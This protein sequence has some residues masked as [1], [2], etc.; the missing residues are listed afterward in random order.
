MFCT[1]TE[2][3]KN[4]FFTLT[5]TLLD[6]RHVMLHKTKSHF[7][8]LV[9]ERDWLTSFLGGSTCKSYKSKSHVQFTSWCLWCS[10]DVHGVCKRNSAPYS[11]P[12]AQQ[13]HYF[14][15]LAM[16]WKFQWWY[17][18]T[19]FIH[20]NFCRC[21]STVINNWNQCIILTA[22]FVFHG[23]HTTWALWLV[24]NYAAP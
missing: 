17:H 23:Q 4:S 21:C 5:S 16:A 8:Q 12:C 24:C 2:K 1:S 3:C 15:H 10:N 13:Y 6:H 9:V 14:Q 19:Q 11:Y 18:W 22:L 7:L 20:V